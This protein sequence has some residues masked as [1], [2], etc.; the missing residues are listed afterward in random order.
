LKGKGGEKLGGGGK[1]SI[2]REG[3]ARTG[4][5]K[6]KRGGFIFLGKGRAAGAPLSNG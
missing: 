2:P 3:A 6:A 4:T 1:K 5:E